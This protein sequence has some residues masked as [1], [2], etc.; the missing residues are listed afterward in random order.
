MKEEVRLHIGRAPLV[1]TPRPS[2]R[3]TAI[4]Y[5]LRLTE[6]NGY[7]GPAIFLPDEES[8]AEARVLRGGRA[9]ALARLALVDETTASRLEIGGAGH[10]YRLLGHTVHATDVSI[11]HHR[12]CPSCIAIDG[13]YDASWHL[14]LVTHC[15]VH[16]CRLV[17]S[18]SQCGRGL[19]INRQG[20]GRC[21]CGAVLEAPADEEQCSSDTAML[22]QAV[23]SRLLDDEISAPFPDRLAVLQDVGLPSLLT[24]LRRLHRYVRGEWLDCQ[25][26]VCRDD[27]AALSVISRAFQSWDQGIQEFNR[28]LRGGSATRRY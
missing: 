1:A 8:L 11:Y 12:I 21:K 27:D 25:R 16:R 10:T 26:L 6:A 20:P 4:G 14:R 18:C 3:E 22:L 7:A 17:G 2:P 19:C 23:R 9:D 13:I 24:L 28:I 5:V 15:P